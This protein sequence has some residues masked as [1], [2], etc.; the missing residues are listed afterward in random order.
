MTEGN[1]NTNITNPNGNNKM[2]MKSTQ[3][4]A[5]LTTIPSS[6]KQAYDYGQLKYK[7]INKSPNYFKRK[8]KS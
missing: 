7:Y 8:N 3:I 5:P 4:K 2:K 1:F 6:Y